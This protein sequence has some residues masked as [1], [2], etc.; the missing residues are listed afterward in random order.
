[1]IWAGTWICW[2]YCYYSLTLFWPHLIWGYPFLFNFGIFFDLILRIFVVVLYILYRLLGFIFA[3][4]ILWHCFDLTIWVNVFRL[5]LF[6][7]CFLEWLLLLFYLL[8]LCKKDLCCFCR[9]PAFCTWHLG[10]A[11]LEV[12]SS[13]CSSS[14]CCKVSRNWWKKH[15]QNGRLF[16]R[17]ITCGFVENRFRLFLQ[18]PALSPGIH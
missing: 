11:G 1:M 12:E 5:K 7:T 4:L 15:G 10:S 8:S 3:V 18:P 16:P 2:L 17:I 14:P 6:S 13:E 9:C